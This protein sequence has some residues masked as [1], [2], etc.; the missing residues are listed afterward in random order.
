[1]RTYGRLQ[2]PT[3]KNWYWTTVTTD[4]NGFDDYVWIL[5]LAQCCLLILGESPFWGDWGIPAQQSVVQQVFPDYYIFLMQQR[6]APHF[7]ALTIA[8]IPNSTPTYKFNVTTNTGVVGQ[9]T[10]VLP[11]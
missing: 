9:Y 11:Q 7:A 8:K 6:F 5:T 4:T 2:D 1:M 3:T 10:V